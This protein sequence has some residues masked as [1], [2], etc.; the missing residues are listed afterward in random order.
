MIT[1]EFTLGGFS[2][3]RAIA[4]GVTRT[5]LDGNVLPFFAHARAH[6][7]CAV[8][9]FGPFFRRSIALQ[10]CMLP[11]PLMLHWFSLKP[12]GTPANAP[13]QST[14]K[15]TKDASRCFIEWW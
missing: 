13:P 10:H 1:A 12:S 6:N 11:M 5:L 3:V 9:T 8:E 2:I 14:S 4:G 15:R 7:N